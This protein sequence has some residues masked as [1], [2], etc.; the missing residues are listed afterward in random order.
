M[1][2]LN[3]CALISFVCDIKV[4]NV[5]L[6]DSGRYVLCDFGSATSDVMVP[7]DQESRQYIEEE[8]SK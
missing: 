3:L 5:L 2:L 4:E 1:E 6:G 8:I 7:T